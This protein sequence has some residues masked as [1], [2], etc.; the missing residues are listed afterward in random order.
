MKSVLNIDINI[1]NFIKE[2]NFT[3]I[4]I[5]VGYLS[6]YSKLSYIA[7]ISSL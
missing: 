7:K 6:Y 1:I 4:I 3:F 5:I 2:F